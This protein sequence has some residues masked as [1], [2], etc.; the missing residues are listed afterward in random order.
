MKKYQIEHFKRRLS[1]LKRNKLNEF[2]NSFKRP[3]YLSDNEKI[4]LFNDG[5]FK[6]KKIIG[7]DYCIN[8]NSYIYFEQDEK[9]KEKLIKIEKEIIDYSTKLQKKVSEIEDTL[10][11]IGIEKATELLKEFE[12]FK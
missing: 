2:S 4:K 3:K 1:E 9:T 7:R 10:I 12:D 5:K 11:F 8:F 6:T